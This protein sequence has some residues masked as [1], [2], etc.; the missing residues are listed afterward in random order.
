STG[1]GPQRLLWPLLGRKFRGAVE[2]HP[3]RLQVACADVRSL[4]VAKRNEPPGIPGGSKALP[5]V[6][7]DEA[8]LRSRAAKKN[9]PLWASRNT[10]REKKWPNSL[11]LRLALYYCAVAYPGG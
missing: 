4:A 1:P 10:F 8:R 6:I 11:W 5:C 2:V 9:V 7:L 3:A